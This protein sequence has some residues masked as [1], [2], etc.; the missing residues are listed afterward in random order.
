[1]MPKFEPIDFVNS[2]IGK[3]MEQDKGKDF[4]LMFQDF[5]N[6]KLRAEYICAGNLDRDEPSDYMV[7]T[8]GMV[9]D[10]I[11]INGDNQEALRSL[12]DF[13]WEHLPIEDQKDV[14]EQLGIKIN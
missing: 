12:R 8:I 2:R 13:V 5:L 14:L 1:M 6:A 10:H 7:T 9:A 11:L 4:V 3:E